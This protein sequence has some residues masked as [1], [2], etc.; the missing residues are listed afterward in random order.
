MKNKWTLIGSLLVV[1]LLALAVGP[2]QAQGPGPQ[3]DVGIQAVLGT[4]FTYQGQLK[5]GGSPVNGNCDFQFSLWD[6]AI[7]GAQVGS[8]QAKTNVAVSDGYF[9]IPDLNFGSTAFQGDAR[10]LQI[11]VRCPAGSGTYTTLSPRQALTAAPYALSLRPGAGIIGGVVGSVLYVQNIHTGI[12]YSIGVEGYAS[13]TTG[14][15]YGVWGQSDSTTGTGVYSRATATTGTTHGVYGRSDST[16]GTGVYGYASAASG[17]TVGVWGESD[18]TNARAVYGR[19]NA[20]TGTA[21]GGFGRSNSPNGTGVW[22]IS[23]TGDG[24]G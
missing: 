23:D 8:T 16:A 3:G 22:G 6:A 1:T 24:V 14:N 20:T 9:T 2:G 19:A 4:A 18:S 17:I 12:L 21:F 10:W 7:G 5:S 13:A 15:T 11:A